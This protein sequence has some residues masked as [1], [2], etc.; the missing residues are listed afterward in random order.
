MLVSGPAFAQEIEETRMVGFAC[1]YEGRETKVVG[2]FAKMLRRKKYATISRALSSSNPAER[3]MAA[4]CLEALYERNIRVVTSDERTLIDEVKTSTENLP[5][6]S[7]CFPH[8]GI[9]L[10]QAFSSD[11]LWGASVWLERQLRD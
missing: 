5:V 10:R 1:F 3:F 4:L 8:P 7:G 6:C 11:M 2:R 9:E